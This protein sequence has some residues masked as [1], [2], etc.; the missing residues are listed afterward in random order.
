MVRIDMTRERA[1]RRECTVRPV[2][3]VGRPERLWTVSLAID[4]LG[5]SPLG[6]GEIL[7]LQWGET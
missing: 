5:R 1:V 3:P 6:L 4:W 2:W 7:S